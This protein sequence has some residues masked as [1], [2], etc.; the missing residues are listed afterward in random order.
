VGIAQTSQEIIHLYG[1]SLPQNF[2]DWVDY[3]RRKNHR[4]FELALAGTVSTLGFPRFQDALFM[5]K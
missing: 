5:G 4:E 2:A 1:L 3:Y